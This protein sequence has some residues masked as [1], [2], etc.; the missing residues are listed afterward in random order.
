[1]CSDLDKSRAKTP[2]KITE[3]EHAYEILN[4]AWYQC[5]IASFIEIQPAIIENKH[6]QTF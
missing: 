2:L 1:M 6:R 5:T 3:P 4:K